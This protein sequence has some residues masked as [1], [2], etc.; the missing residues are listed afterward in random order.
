MP[1]L[2]CASFQLLPGQYIARSTMIGS[3]ADTSIET[4]VLGTTV[5]DA[6]RRPALRPRSACVRVT[7][8]PPGSR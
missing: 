3:V 4:S 7:T 1:A 2:A 8:W 5:V 6:D